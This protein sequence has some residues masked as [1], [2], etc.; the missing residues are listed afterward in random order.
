MVLGPTRLCLRRWPGHKLAGQDADDLTSEIMLK[1]FEDEQRAL[2][3]W[4]PERGS[5]GNYVSWFARSR[6]KEFER[7]ELRRLELVPATVDLDSV[8]EPKEASQRPDLLAS[9]RQFAQKIRDCLARKMPGE[10]A[11]R[12]IELIYDRLLDTDAIVDEAG[13]SRD[14]VSRLRYLIRTNA[15]KCLEELQKDES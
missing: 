3:R 11:N 10:K 14:Q 13:I 1:L 15:A 7:K 5:L 2:S 8:A 12:M 6:P 9:A 4:D